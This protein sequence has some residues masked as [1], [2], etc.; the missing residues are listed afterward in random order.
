MKKYIILLFIVIVGFSVNDVH[1]EFITLN[2]GKIDLANDINPNKFDLSF[3]NANYLGDENSLP[4][5]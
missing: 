3:E 2:W 4:V 5:Y 1:K